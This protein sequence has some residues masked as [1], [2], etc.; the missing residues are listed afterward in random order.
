MKIRSGFVSNSSSASFVILDKRKMTEEEIKT[1]YD[2]LKDI[3]STITETNNVIEVWE[4]Y[5]VTQHVR[6][7]CI[8]KEYDA[9]EWP[10]APEMLM[11]IY[12]E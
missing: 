6:K 2:V 8:L 12:G 3:N 10:S 5:K 1:V 11:A 7:E 4:G 9:R